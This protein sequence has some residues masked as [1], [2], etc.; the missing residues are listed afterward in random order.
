LRA[1]PPTEG[2]ALEPRQHD[3]QDEQIVGLQFGQP[4]PCLAVV[5]QIDGVALLGQ[6]LPED[7]RQPVLVFHHQYPQRHHQTEGRRGPTTPR[8]TP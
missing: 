8:R 2:I 1:Q 3:I 7:R 6:A 4:E 5:R